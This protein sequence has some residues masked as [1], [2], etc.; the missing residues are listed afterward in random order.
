MV[1]EVAVDL[2]VVVAVKPFFILQENLKKTK[3]TQVFNIQ[4]VTDDCFFFKLCKMIRKCF[5]IDKKPTTTIKNVNFFVYAL[6]D[7]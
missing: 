4:K 5:I 6:N 2:E 1:L 7:Y 3:L